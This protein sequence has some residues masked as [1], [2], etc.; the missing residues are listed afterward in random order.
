MRP[1]AALIAVKGELYGTTSG[2]GA[3]SFGVI[4]GV[5]EK[6][7]TESVLRSF[8]EDYASDGIYPQASLI[9]VNGTLYGTTSKGGL[10]PPSCPYSGIC[11]WGTV[12]AFKQ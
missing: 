2:G 7:G 1:V 5:N 10:N 3:A 6:S 12:F 11:D 9:N 8:G 4:F